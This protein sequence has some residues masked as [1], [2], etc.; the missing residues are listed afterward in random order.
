MKYKLL[1]A[2]IAVVLAEISAFLTLQAY[3]TSPFA[4]LSQYPIYYL[5][6]I[7]PIVLVLMDRNPYSLSFFAILILFSFGRILANSEVFYSFLDALYFFK[8]YDLSDYLY[9]IFSPYKAQDISH[10][11]TLT[12][13]FVAS[14]LVWNACLKAELLDKE[15][16]EVKDTLTFQIV[17]VSLISFA[18]YAVYPH[19]LNVLKT[20]HQIPMLFAGL[21]GVVLF[22]ISAYLLIKQ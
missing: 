18:I 8:F 9:S 1:G 12:W 5:L 22:L 4:L 6:F 19:V 15:G 10:F 7:I 20:T 17:A 14:Q 13:L 2:I 11:L 3:L 16:F 21:I